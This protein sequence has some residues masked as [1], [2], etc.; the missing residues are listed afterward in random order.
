[1]G[2]GARRCRRQAVDAWDPGP[3][4]TPSQSR[5]RA[6]EL[7][8]PPHIFHPRCRLCG[9][10]CC[11][12]EGRLRRW[13]TSATTQCLATEV[14]GSPEA[15]ERVHL[16]ASVQACVWRRP[17]Y[18]RRACS[19]PWPWGHGVVASLPCACAGTKACASHVVRATF[20]VCADSITCAGSQHAIPW[21]SATSCP[22]PTLWMAQCLEGIRRL[23]APCGHRIDSHLSVV[24]VSQ[25][26]S[27]SS[28][29]DQSP[30][31]RTMPNRLK[32][33]L[34]RSTPQRR[35]AGPRPHLWLEVPDLSRCCPWLMDWV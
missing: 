14:V 11:M 10:R 32:S 17:E 25:P 27:P 9:S 8:R 30:H 15:L 3:A 5:D 24:G 21:P 12:L 34:L 26:C 20:V 31:R 4:L 16:G 29:A 6:R 1:M 28:P 13:L 18:R 23:A 2:H 33:L 35:R 7:A 19:R 22:P